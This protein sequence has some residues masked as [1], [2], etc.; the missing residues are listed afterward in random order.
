MLEAIRRGY[1]HLYCLGFD[2]LLKDNELSTDNV[3][4]NQQ[5]YGP[6]THANHLDN[7]HRVRYLEWFMRKHSDVQFTFVLPDD[8]PFQ[9]LTAENVRGQFISKFIEKRS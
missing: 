8:E 4:K 7:V 6:E 1:D 3:F 2:F 9:S 5:G